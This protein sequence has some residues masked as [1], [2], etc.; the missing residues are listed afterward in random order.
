M[1]KQLRHPFG[2]PGKQ[3]GM[4]HS[5][6]YQHA[7]VHT[8][9]LRVTRCMHVHRFSRSKVDSPL[10]VNAREQKWSCSDMRK[11][12][13]APRSRLYP[14]AISNSFLAELFQDAIRS[15]WNVRRQED[16]QQAQSLGRRI[17]N[18][19]ETLLLP[20]PLCQSPRLTLFDVLIGV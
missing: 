19:V 9:P 14:G 12:A 20:G 1:A 8:L 2:E 17:E 3:R 16:G 13:T 15:R 10:G 6:P 4:V 5:S 11:R 7:T 18:R